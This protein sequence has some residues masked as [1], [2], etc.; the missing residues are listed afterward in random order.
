MSGMSS[1]LHIVLDWDIPSPN[2]PNEKGELPL[3][4]L[5]SRK[6]SSRNRGGNR[7]IRHFNTRPSRP[8]IP[9]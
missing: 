6:D 9:R 1:M 4:T 7:S 5:P 3:G 2:E 8:G